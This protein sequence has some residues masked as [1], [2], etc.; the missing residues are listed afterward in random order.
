[1]GY[2]VYDLDDSFFWSMGD[3]AAVTI[4]L[5]RKYHDPEKQAR[6]AEEQT[7]KS[8]EEL[9]LKIAPSEASNDQVAQ[10]RLSYL[11]SRNE[12]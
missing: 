6:L 10:P 2:T 7:G 11:D 4:I 1:V 5:N 8:R 3:P 12:A 9:G